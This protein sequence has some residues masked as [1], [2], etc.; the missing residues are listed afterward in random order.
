MDG[1]MGACPED[2]NLV[3]AA[4]YLGVAPWEL[5]KQSIW[6]RERAIKFMNAETQAAQIRKQ[7]GG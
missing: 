6:W 1:K 2:Y 3:K 4:Q 7:H 5:M